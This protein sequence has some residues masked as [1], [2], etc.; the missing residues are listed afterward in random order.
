MGIP[1]ILFSLPLCEGG[2]SLR[3]KSFLGWDTYLW[4]FFSSISPRS[5]W[6]RPSPTSLWLL[7]VPEE[8]SAPSPFTSPDFNKWYIYTHMSSL[9]TSPS[10]LGN[11]T[12]LYVLIIVRCMK[13]ENGTLSLHRWFTYDPIA[14]LAFSSSISELNMKWVYC[15]W[16]SPFWVSLIHQMLK[17]L[18]ALS[19]S[20]QAG[21]SDNSLS[22]FKI[23]QKEFKLIKN[24]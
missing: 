5:W 12:E 9:L 14:H 18:N 20:S 1:F 16:F 4:L 17:S 8:M 13:N 21:L 19:R 22:P 3:W 10:F 24:L 7:F 2:E 23:S 6:F 11:Q 15:V